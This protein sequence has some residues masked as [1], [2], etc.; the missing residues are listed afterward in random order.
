MRDIAHLVLSSS[1]AEQ[2]GVCFL[3]VPSKHIDLQTVTTLATTPPHQPSPQRALLPV[4]CHLPPKKILKIST[5]TQPF[6]FG[7]GT[8]G[9][10]GKR[11][12]VYLAYQL[13]SRPLPI[14]NAK[15]YFFKPVLLYKHA[16][17]HQ[18]DLFTKYIYIHWQ[19]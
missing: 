6:Y 5:K 3:S 10:D 14:Q 8:F 7:K 12:L 18:N 11:K 1:E 2:R 4:I 19:F 15:L 17:K 9:K 16:H 13:L